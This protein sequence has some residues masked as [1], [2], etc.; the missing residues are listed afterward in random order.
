MKWERNALWGKMWWY[1]KVWGKD[2]AR[3]KDGEET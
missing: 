2:T 3:E 1:R